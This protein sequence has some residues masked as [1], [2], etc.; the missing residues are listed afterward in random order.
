MM[1][2]TIGKILTLFLAFILI[3]SSAIFLSPYAR[4]LLLRSGVVKEEIYI[5]GTGSMYPT[6][7]KSEGEDELVLAQHI[8]AWPKMRRYPSDIN[9]FGFNLF[10]Y[11]LRHGDIVEFDNEKTEKIT[12]KKY[13]QPAGFVKRIIAVAGDTVELRDGFVYL[14]GVILD[15]PY[16]AKPRS[17]YGGEYLTDCQIVKVPNNKAF[18]LGDN[19]KASLDSRHEVGL[20]DYNDINHVLPWKEQEEYKYLWRDTF[21]DLTLA[22]T[23]SVDSS[24]FVKLINE[25]RKEK[26]L[27]P[28]SYNTLLS[29]SAKRRGDAMIEFNDFSSE[30]TKS[31]VDLKKSIAESGYFNILFAEVFTRGFYEADE[32]L[33][34]FLAFPD[35]ENILFSKEYQDFGIEAV[36]GEINNCPVQVIVA[37]LG[38]YVPPNYTQKQIGSWQNLI[39]NLNDVLPSW[40]KLLQVEGVDKEKVNKLVNILKTRLSNAEIILDRMKANQWLTEKEREMVDSDERL[41][42][43][44][45]NIISSFGN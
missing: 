1:L 6:F 40:E 27:K 24:Q 28:F 21:H 5:S 45:E 30:A 35:T 19:R 25:K 44:A 22:H 11:Q 42:Q 12:Q 39:S 32:L 4:E 15:E 34:N 16:S 20:V 2:K 10:S 13:G 3:F 26:N 9:L 23:P 14:N 17:S 43:E 29:L 33:D 38:G 36:L 31:G 41:A 37:H 18:V 8:V 7:P